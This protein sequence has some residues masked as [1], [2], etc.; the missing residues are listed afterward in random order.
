[1]TITVGRDSDSGRT[2]VRVGLASEA[3]A[4]PHEH[5]ELHRALAGG[6]LPGARLQRERPAVEP[7]VG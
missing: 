2:T 1:L 4:M 7:V 5:E 3:D 6:L